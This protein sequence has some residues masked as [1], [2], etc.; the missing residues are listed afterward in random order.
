MREKTELKACPFCGSANVDPEGWAATDQ[1]GGNYR[2][3]PCCDDCGASADSVERWNTR[4]QP[5]PQDQGSIPDEITET[6]IRSRA[7]ALILKNGWKPGDRPGLHSVVEL[8]TAIGMHVAHQ[9]PTDRCAYPECGCD[10]DATCANA[11][12]SVHAEKG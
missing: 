7:K 6:A 9:P 2:T 3:G 8:M 5:T 4:A 10:F 12:P 11:P 1:T